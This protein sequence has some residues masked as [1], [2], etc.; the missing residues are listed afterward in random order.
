MTFANL[1]QC[2]EPWLRK[3]LP[4]RLTLT[5]THAADTAPVVPTG[6]GKDVFLKDLRFGMGFCPGANP[7]D[8]RNKW[9]SL[10]EEVLWKIGYLTIIRLSG[11]GNWQAAFWMSFGELLASQSTHTDI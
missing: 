9:E 3:L 7:H 1:V 2:K 10:R 6:W 5:H 8:S 11:P 4:P